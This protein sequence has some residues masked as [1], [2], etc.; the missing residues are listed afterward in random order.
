MQ[1]KYVHAFKPWQHNKT[2][3]RIYIKHCKSINMKNKNNAYQN[4]HNDVL[5]DDV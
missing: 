5:T 4:S 3:L 1:I 2:L